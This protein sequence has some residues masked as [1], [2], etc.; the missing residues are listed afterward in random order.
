MSQVFDNKSNNFQHQ[1]LHRKLRHAIRISILNLEWSAF[2]KRIKIKPTIIE[3]VPTLIQAIEKNFLYERNFLIFS[4]QS[5]TVKNQNCCKHHCDQ[6]INKES[7]RTK[8][9]KLKYSFSMKT[10][11][12]SL[13]KYEFFKQDQKFDQQ[14]KKNIYQYFEK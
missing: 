8:R 5:I 1:Q 3:N 14:C 7:D 2:S 9:L 4:K 11:F 6:V 13:E 12:F 10:C